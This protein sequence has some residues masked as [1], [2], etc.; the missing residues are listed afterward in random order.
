MLTSHRNRADRTD[1]ATNGGPGLRQH[2]HSFNTRT[3]LL[4]QRNPLRCR[5]NGPA[6]QSTGH[7]HPDSDPH[8]HSTPLTR[9]S[10]EACVSHPRVSRRQ[11]CPI[12]GSRNV[13][14]QSDRPRSAAFPT[15]TR[16]KT[17]FLIAPRHCCAFLLTNL[18]MHSLNDVVKRPSVRRG[19]RNDTQCR[20]VHSKCR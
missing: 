1:S 7:T 4:T 10:S 9:I 14:L 11:Q 20:N 16:H 3:K 5:E 8:A 2:N 13:T 6:P 15:A 17:T 12:I 18:Q 19:T